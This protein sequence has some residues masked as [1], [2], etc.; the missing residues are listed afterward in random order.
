[1]KTALVELVRLL[2]EV[3]AEE[4]VIE[5][6]EHFATNKPAY[7]PSPTQQSSIKPAITNTSKDF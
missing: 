6:S 2:A 4:L 5:Q 1:M 3:V 7:F